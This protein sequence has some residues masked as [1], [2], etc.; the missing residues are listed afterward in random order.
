MAEVSLTSSISGDTSRRRRN[1]NGKITGK[2][3]PGRSSWCKGPEAL[4][5]LEK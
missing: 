2:K 1:C 3:E 5:W 4:G